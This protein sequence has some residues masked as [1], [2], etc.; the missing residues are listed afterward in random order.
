M[1]KILISGGTGLVGRHLTKLLEKKG[2]K[3]AI[4]SRNPKEENEFKWDVKR[5]Y[6]DKKAF[7]DVTHV[8]HLAGAGIA[9]TRWNE[10]RKKIIIKSRVNSANLL[11]K[12]IQEF[13]IPIKGFIS[14]SGIGFYGA[15]TSDHIF[16]ENDSPANDFIATV[17]KKWEK[18]ANQFSKLSIPVTI[19]RTGIVLS[20]NGGALEKMNTP[21]F[22]AA[23]G[24]GKQYMPWIHIDDLCNLYAKAIEDSNF[25]G[26]FNAVAPNSDTNKTFTKTLGKVLSKYVLPIHIPSFIL[27]GILG[28][29]AIILLEGSRISSKKTAD[30]YDFKFPDLTTALQNNYK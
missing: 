20:K 26:V 14:A 19:L 28:E 22:L 12:K 6:I 9:D 3:V 23:L 7:K 13:E 16:E 29:L 11:F 5:G 25:N 10:K 2:Y 17:C 18:A 4:L 1:I 27:K 30:F 8:I 21:L 24:S 15:I